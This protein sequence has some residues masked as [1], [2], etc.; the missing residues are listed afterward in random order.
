MG[1]R[2]GGRRESRLLVCDVV[3]NILVLVG[4]EEVR[5]QFSEVLLKH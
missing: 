1:E 5:T 4:R 2:E 3:L